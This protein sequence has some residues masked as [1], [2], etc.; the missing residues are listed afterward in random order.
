MMKTFSTRKDAYGCESACVTNV[1][2]TDHTSLRFKP[3][4]FA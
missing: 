2:A 3:E 4:E 1:V